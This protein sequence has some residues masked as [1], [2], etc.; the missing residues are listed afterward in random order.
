MK[1]REFLKNS[2]A[3]ASVLCL[4][5][6]MTA[7]TAQDLS[8]A[9]AVNLIGKLKASP[10]LRSVGTQTPYQ[11][12]MHCV[13][14]VDCALVGYPEMKASWFQH[15]IGQA[16]FHA[17]SIMDTMK[18]DRTAPIPGLPAAEAEGDVQKALARLEESFRTLQAA[19]E[20]RPHFFFGALSHQD[21][22]RV[23]VMHFLNHLEHLKWQQA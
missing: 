22:E 14:S 19:H 7:C 9:H 23:Q 3:G 13:Q 21:M 4:A 10:H 6:V 5:P 20:V 18:H 17:F 1:R 11:I 2:L 16:A 8:T 12:I 15:S